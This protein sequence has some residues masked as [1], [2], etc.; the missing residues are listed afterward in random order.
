ML[1]DYPPGRQNTRG[2]RWNPSDV[3]AIY[4]S[5]EHETAIAE[6]EYRLSMEPVRPRA[7]RVIY[8][9]RVRLSS[10]LDLRDDKALRRLGLNNITEANF[11]VCQ[12]V[13][14]AVHWL[15]HDGLLVPSARSNGTN[16]V[17]YPLK[18]DPTLDFEIVDS[19]I[20]SE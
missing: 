18:H 3:A 5:C 9:L 2:A 12:Q 20:I 15:D 1:N 16:L 8:S 6:G 4:T 7:K 19:V 10:V 17:I 11:S 14:G 13:G